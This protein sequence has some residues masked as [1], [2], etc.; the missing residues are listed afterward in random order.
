MKTRFFDIMTPPNMISPK[1]VPELPMILVNNVS[2]EKCQYTPTLSVIQ[3]SRQAMFPVAIPPHIFW[4]MG[5]DEDEHY[6][7]LAYNLCLMRLV[8][9]IFPRTPALD[10]DTRLRSVLS[11]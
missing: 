1:I 4:N 3:L 2:G 10:S 6:S 7:M 5:Y 8:E 11:K 9:A